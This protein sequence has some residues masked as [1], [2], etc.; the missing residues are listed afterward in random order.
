MGTTG[1]QA[2]VCVVG[3]RVEAAL[4]PL[5]W[6]ELAVLS[7]ASHVTLTMIGPEASEEAS[8]ATLYEGSLGHSRVSIHTSRACLKGQVHPTEEDMCSAPPDAFVLYNPGLGSIHK[9]L[10]RDSMQTILRS[11]KP[12][13]L[14]AYDQGDSARDTSWLG[15][16]QGGCR[17]SYSTNPWASLLPCHNMHSRTFY[18]HWISTPPALDHVV[19][20]APL[21]AVDQLLA[22]ESWPNSRVAIIPPQTA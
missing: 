21:G 9:Y 3:A 22:N 7:G 14:T 20:S 12:V 13:L 5:V 11:R 18:Q 8:E 6:D 16:Q 1:T 15:L 4:P 19:A 2:S 10:W 17:L